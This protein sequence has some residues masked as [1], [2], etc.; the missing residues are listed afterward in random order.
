[1]NS[2]TGLAGIL[3]SDA[4]RSNLRRELAN[5]DVDHDNNVSMVT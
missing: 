3:S 2:R 5:T 1:M 4:F